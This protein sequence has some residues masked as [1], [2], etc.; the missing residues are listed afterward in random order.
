MEYTGDGNAFAILGF[1]QRIIKA[2]GGDVK[3]YQAAATEGDYNHLLAVSALWTGV[4][5]TAYYQ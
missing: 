4:D 3:K 5:F 2:Q 1:C